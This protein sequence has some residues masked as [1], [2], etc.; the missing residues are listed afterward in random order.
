M[1][2]TA[3][4]RTL[5]EAH[6]VLASAMSNLPV[7]LR[8]AVRTIGRVVRAAGVTTVAAQDNPRSRRTVQ[9][10]AEAPYGYKADGT[11]RAKPGRKPAIA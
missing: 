2:R 7:E 1:S 3:D 5:V 4:P 9:R 10:S 6:A 8:G 11:P